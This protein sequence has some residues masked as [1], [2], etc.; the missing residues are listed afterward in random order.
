MTLQEV[1]AQAAANVPDCLAAGYVDTS[2]GLLLGMNATESHP[3]EILDLVATATTDL[4]QGDSVVAIEDYFKNARG[5]GGDDEHF[6]QEIIINSKNL[7]HVFLRTE[8][9][10]DHIIVFV[11]RNTANIG[12]MLSKSRR[13]VAKIVAII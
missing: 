11:G 13:E 5:D 10:P 9:R 7:F 12:L 6:F 3:Q 8:K 2:S 4:F 1:L